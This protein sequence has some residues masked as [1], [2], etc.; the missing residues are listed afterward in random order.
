[1]ERIEFIV[2]LFAWGHV[3]QWMRVIVDGF[4]PVYLRGAGRRSTS[5]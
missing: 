1:M 2:R 5:D 3:L 4:D